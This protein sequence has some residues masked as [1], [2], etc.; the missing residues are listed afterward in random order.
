[1]MKR[2]YRITILSAI[3]AFSACKKESDETLPVNKVDKLDD[4]GILGEWEIESRSING[5]DDMLPI[6]CE[7]L[8]FQTGSNMEDL[9]GNV[10]YLEIDR[11]IA[12]KFEIDQ[13]NMTIEFI[14]EDY[15]YSSKLEIK[16]NVMHLT[17]SNEGLVIE[18][19]WV[20]VK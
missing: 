10:R 4:I 12:G 16:D 7:F 3:L 9:N 20:R 14:F 5:I 15:N 11:D 19:A 1:M 8:D 6:C 2:I 18:D 13:A 17:Y